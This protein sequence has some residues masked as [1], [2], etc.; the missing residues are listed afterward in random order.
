MEP[1]RRAVLAASILGSALVFLDLSSVNVF[2][3][4]LQREFGTGIGAVQWVVEAFTLLLAALLLAGGAVADRYGRKRIFLLG[5][6]V[7]AGG[8]LAAALSPTILLLIASRAVQGIG[9]ALLAPASLALIAQAF[10]AKER[11]G[12]FGT[13]AA[14]TG[15]G[16]AGGPLVAGFLADRVSWRAYFLVLALIAGIAAF[17]VLRV[18]SQGAEERTKA[19]LD[20]KGATLATLTL[21]GLTF[22]LV[23]ANARGFR[24]AWVIGALLLGAASFALFLVV[25]RRAAS[26]MLPLRLFRDKAFSGANLAT[27]LVYAALSAALFL[28]PFNLIQ[29]QG[30]S[31]TAAG[32]A[33][34]P[35][36]LTMASLSRPLGNLADRVGPRWPTVLGA[37]VTA[38][39]FALLARPGISA[40]YWTTFF[41]GF[42]LLGLGMAG[43]I[44]ALTAT[45]MSRVPEKDTGMASAV[46]NAVART[47]GV[48]AIALAGIVAVLVFTQTL[49]PDAREAIGTDVTRLADVDVPPGVDARVVDAAFVRA[50]RVVMIL[51]A[52]FAAAGSVVAA[53]TFPRALGDDGGGTRGKA[54]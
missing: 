32:A 38:A 10:P 16:A 27:L 6:G 4:V 47:A 22:G 9:A 54:R 31:A 44:P 52:G 18:E 8:A 39:G 14:A 40:N 43:L 7:Y 2:L 35:F 15:F 51:A 3:P 41:P 20:I 36:A 28:V 12:A 19:R 11:S 45:V 33:T 25:E 34:L 13:W 1:E 24:D 49:P 53:L 50:Y 37:A 42:L 23:E 5:I 29:L 46:N 21:G 48:L 26:P 17:L 30:W